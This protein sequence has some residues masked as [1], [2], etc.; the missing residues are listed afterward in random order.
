MAN[1]K[2]PKVQGSW[3]EGWGERQSLASSWARLWLLRPSFAVIWT[4]AA[5]WIRISHKQTKEEKAKP[6]KTSQRMP[7]NPSSRAHRLLDKDNDHTR[8]AK[9]SPVKQKT[10]DRVLS[11][12]LVWMPRKEIPQLA[13]PQRSKPVIQYDSV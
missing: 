6:R 12:W 3:N 13:E 2:Q 8:K 11:K 9:N 4:P 1:M 7:R 5:T 10:W